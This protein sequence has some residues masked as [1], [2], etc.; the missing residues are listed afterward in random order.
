MIRSFRIDV[1]VPNTLRAEIVKSSLEATL[2]D[3]AWVA[4]VYMDEMP[5]ET[6]ARDR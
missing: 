1:Q 3:G 6:I 5:T 4:T 2:E